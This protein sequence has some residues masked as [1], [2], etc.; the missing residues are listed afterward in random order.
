MKRLALFLAAALAFFF[1]A[2]AVSDPRAFFGGGAAPP[3]RT[4]RPAVEAALARFDAAMARYLADG[5]E[6]P[7]R[8]A[9]AAPEDPGSPLA[10]WR[11]QRAD[12]HARGGGAPEAVLLERRLLGVR[13]AGLDT[14]LASAAEAWETRY[15]G[16]P[17]VRSEL[18]AQYALTRGPSGLRVASLA[19]EP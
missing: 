9:L 16:G 2:Y 12:L 17:A 3:E 10:E 15:P 6:G 5:D 8:E 4:E 18:V 14:V 7:A 19:V 11:L 1:G 13:Q